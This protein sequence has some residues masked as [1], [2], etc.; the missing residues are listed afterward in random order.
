[1]TISTLITGK[2]RTGTT[3][4]WSR[5]A[6]R[7]VG[8]LVVAGTLACGIASAAAEQAVSLFKIITV[9]DEIVVGVGPQDAAALGGSDVT[10][11]GRALKGGGELTV[12][13]YAV[14]KAPDGELE[15]APL[16][17]I[18]IIGNDS[19]RVEPYATPL[20]VVAPK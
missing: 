20:R 17:R 3:R 18:S 2:T 19:L 14:R 6:R 10:A 16:R 8:T 9:R 11:V 15:Q 5:T 7:L 13:Q 1:M 12:W 4:N